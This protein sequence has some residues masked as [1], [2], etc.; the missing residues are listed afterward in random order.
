MREALNHRKSTFGETHLIRGLCTQPLHHLVRYLLEM[1][2]WGT[3]AYK[4]LHSFD[5]PAGIGWKAN[6]R[7]EVRACS[8]G[9]S[10]RVDV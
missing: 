8:S 9:R 7:G 5:E 6:S 3:I 1:R 2:L 4:P 10:S